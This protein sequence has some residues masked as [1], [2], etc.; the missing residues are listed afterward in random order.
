MKITCAIAAFLLSIGHLAAEITVD[1]IYGSGMVLQQGR[2]I[3][4]TG[5]VTD[6]PKSVTVQFAGQNVKAEVKGKQWRAKL[7]PMPASAEGQTMTIKQG[8]KDSVTLDNVRVGEVWLASGQSNMLWRL[9]QTGDRNA[10]AAANHPNL[11]FYHNEPQIHTNPRHYTDAEKQKL[12]D[13]QMYAGSWAVSSPT[14]SQRMSA[15]GF[16]FGRKLQETLGVPVGIIHSSLGGSEM[17]AWMPTK[18]VGKKYREC[19]TPKWLE[20][21]YMSDWVRGR[22]SFNNRGELEAPH[23][24]QPTYL[25]KTGIQP[26]ENFP[27]AGVIWYQGESDAE[28]QDMQQ[29]S[30]LLKDLIIGWRAEFKSPELPFLMVQLPRI[31]DKSAL[32]AYWPEFRHVQDQVATQLPGVD[33]IVTTDLGSTNSDVHPPR[34]LEVG[35]RLANLAAAKVYGKDIPAYA[36]RIKDV[37]KAGNGRLVLSFEHASELKTTDGQPPRHFE[38]AGKDGKYYPADA[39][40]E[41]STIVLS[42]PQVASPVTARYAWFTYLTPNLVNEHQLP[43]A[44]FSPEKIKK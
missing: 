13:G 19:L 29:N 7:Q 26:W 37:A 32:R 27:I 36:P 44:P 12:K 40:I 17:M 39:T 24:Y 31:N 16:Y 33:Y 41:G 20:S 1:D 3:P 8:D 30:K 22:A 21:K 10:I 14:S 42:S 11:S 25:Y 34:K 6:G 35:E 38:L 18:V 4:I 15:V 2:V 43:V 23:P 28:I 9:N 5:T